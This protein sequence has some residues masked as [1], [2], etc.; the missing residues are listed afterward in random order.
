MTIRDASSTSGT[1]A[2][3]LCC[4]ILQVLLGRPDFGLSF[5][6]EHYEARLTPRSE[7]AECILKYCPFCGQVL[8]E[9]NR[10][11]Q[12]ALTLLDLAS[13]LQT[14]AEVSEVFGKPDKII[15]PGPCSGSDPW[16]RS[17]YF[18][19]GLGGL[20][21]RINEY[22]GGRLR[23]LVSIPDSEYLRGLVDLGKD[24]E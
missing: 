12:A 6:R 10:G 8:P 18:W 23:R 21:M 4:K 15:D 24:A 1:P 16:I 19:S 9:S 3:V 5:D 22:D 7:Q 2:P 17:W 11:D 20:L 13:R 14:L